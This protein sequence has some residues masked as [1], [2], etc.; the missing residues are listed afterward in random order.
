[1]K[2]KPPE[3][4]TGERHALLKDGEEGIEKVE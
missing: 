3:N 2:R 1:L 4:L